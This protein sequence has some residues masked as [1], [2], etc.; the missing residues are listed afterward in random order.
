MSEHDRAYRLVFGAPHDAVT[1]FRTLEAEAA[2]LREKVAAL[3]EECRLS[4]RTIADERARHEAALKEAETRDERYVVWSHEHSCWWRANSQ[5]YARRIED[6]GVYSRA[7][8]VSISHRGRDGW[9]PGER[10][11]ELPV[12]VSDLPE[13]ARAALSQH[14]GASNAE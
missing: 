14:S 1:E 5:G 8:A 13:F 11:D 3:D 9:R 10:P 6:A 2:E 7:E 4:M 12:R